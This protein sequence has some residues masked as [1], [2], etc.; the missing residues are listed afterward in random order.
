VHV[1]EEDVEVWQGDVFYGLRTEYVQVPHIH[2]GPLRRRLQG[3]I[4][5]DETGPILDAAAAQ[6]VSMVGR[7]GGTTI[8][9]PVA[10]TPVVDQQAATKAGIE[11]ALESVRQNHVVL[12]AQLEDA[13]LHFDLITANEGPVV[14]LCTLNQVDP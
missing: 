4:A 13:Q 7:V 8:G 6:M 12:R 9:T 1:L 10:I 11:A 3:V 14:G 2:S 5:D